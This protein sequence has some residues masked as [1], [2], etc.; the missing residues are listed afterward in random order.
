[1]AGDP[2]SAA[3]AD[4]SALSRVDDAFGFDGLPSPRVLG[5]DPFPPGSDLGGVTIVRLLAEGGMGR[6][7]AGRQAAPDRTVAVKVLRAGLG[8]ADL[9]RRF[10]DEARVLA[11]LH[12]PA[13]AQIFTFGTHDD[14][15]GVVPFFVMEMVEA[16]RPINR[17]VVENG[18]GVREIVAL[19]QRVC[20]AV[21]HGHQKGVIHRDLKPGNVL[22]DGDGEPKVIDFGVARST[23]ADV[24]FTTMH[25]DVGT[26]VGTIQYMSPEQFGADPS[27]LDV[28][29]DVYALGVIQI[30]RAHV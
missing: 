24:A 2:Q 19:L 25:T 8:S 18:L 17:H 13:I 16:A 15:A 28:R 9:V 1:M 22:V 30:G 27:D 20:G 6:V 23:D 3:A 14:G 26:L 7:Y 11:R 4:A 29:L 21:A 5:E 10:R 12:H